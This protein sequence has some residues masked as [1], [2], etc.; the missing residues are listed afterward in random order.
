MNPEKFA[1]ELELINNRDM[2]EQ[3]ARMFMTELNKQL[4]LYPQLKNDPLILKQ[5]ERFEYDLSRVEIDWAQEQL[6]ALQKF[7]SE[8]GMLAGE[9]DENS[10][11]A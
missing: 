10:T 8:R 4:R 6:A 9:V 3:T 1:Q 11:V 7:K 5:I 2:S